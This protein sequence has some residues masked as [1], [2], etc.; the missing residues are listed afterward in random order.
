MGYKKFLDEKD[1]QIAAESLI[2]QRK[3]KTGK[4][5]KHS[6]CFG[7]ESAFAEHIRMG[8]LPGGQKLKVV[9]SAR[10]NIYVI[11]SRFPKRIGYYRHGR[12]SDYY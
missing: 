1:L 11:W 6:D 7:L 5:Q 8:A 2:S 12:P 4:I 3:L 9:L 10:L